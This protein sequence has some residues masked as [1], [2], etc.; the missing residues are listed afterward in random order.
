MDK[1]WIGMSRNTPQYVTGVENFLDF[2][3]S[4][5][6]D[7]STILCPCLK[8]AFNKLHTRDTVFDHLF[9]KQ[10]PSDYILWDIHGEKRG[11]PSNQIRFRRS[12]NNAQSNPTPMEVDDHVVSMH[13]LVHDAFG[14][15]AN[16]IPDD[17]FVVNDAFGIASDDHDPSVV[18]NVEF[19]RHIKDG[20][21]KLYDG[22]KFSKLS[23]LLRLY[24]IKYMHKI[25]EKALGQI[26]ELL[27]E[28]FE[29]TRLSKSVYEAK[30]TIKALGLSYQKIHACPNDCMLY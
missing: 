13:S 14:I 25:S 29:S 17:H 22:C 11:Q 26:L 27:Q 16:P 8:C 4:N 2:A 6:R 12:S 19:I 21:E 15:P 5:S 9:Q 24:H 7:R 28:A 10:F 18:E 1:S 30:K 3:F 20:E 23:F